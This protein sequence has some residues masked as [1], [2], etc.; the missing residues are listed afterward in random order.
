MSQT[1]DDA[2]SPVRPKRDSLFLLAELRDGQGAQLGSIR[3][4]NLSATGLMGECA[5]P[6]DK[7]ARVTVSLRNLGD[8]QASVSW[9]RD[10]RIGLA[11]DMAIDPLAV[12]R[13][14]ASGAESAFDPYKLTR[15]IA[16]KRTPG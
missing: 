6:L 13:P 11:F 4:R 9:W 10:G 5:R 3:I 15:G 8:I 2:A 1:A 7:D 16:S 12:R 14:I